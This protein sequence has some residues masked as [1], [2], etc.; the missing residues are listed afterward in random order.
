MSRLKTPV[1]DIRG[2]KVGGKNPV[3]IQSMTNTDTSDTKSTAKQIMELADAG[4]ELVR[5]TVNTN[6]AAPKV[7]EIRR[8]LDDSGYSHLPLIGDF[9]FNGHTLLAEFPEC[10][11]ALDKFRINPGNVGYGD[12]HDYNFAT[13]VKIALEYDKPVRIGVN[14]G[15]LDQELLT[16]LMNKNSKLSHPKSDREVIIDAMVESALR[17]AELAEGVGLKRNRII[18][19]VKMSVVEDMIKAYELLARRMV[20]KQRLYSLHLGLT[21]AGGGMQGIV[22]SSAALAILLNQ[23]IGDTLR[24][25]LTQQ[26]GQPRTEEVEACKALLQSLGLRHYRPQVTS[27]PGCG[28]TTSTFFQSLAQDVN[29]HIDKKMKQWIQK[30]PGVEELK[31]AVMGCVVNGPG[32]SQHADIAIS[33]P[34]TSEKPV[35]P[36]YIKGKFIKSLKGD[37][38]MEEFVTMIETYLAANY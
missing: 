1:I 3:V 17:S 16:E 30:Y 18:L 28:R 25:S 21:E 4:S 5:I 29:K 20:K 6:L 10:A 35:A 2:V 27:C 31:I 24:I 36:V 9:H 11:K 34:G 7:P 22:S 19:S 32:E 13:I 23:G 12:K 38:I 37:N 26:P 14:W 15:S 8:I 33:L